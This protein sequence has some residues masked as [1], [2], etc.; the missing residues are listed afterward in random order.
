MKKV[1]SAVQWLLEQS[2]IGYLI[3]FRLKGY[4]GPSGLPEAPWHNAVLKSRAEVTSALE[5]VAKLDLPE[6]GDPPKN[7]DSLAALDC[8]VRS[9]AREAC[10]LD[11]G[12][13]LYSRI[14][15]WLALYGYRKLHGINLVFDRKIK[16]GPITYQY[17]DITH[18]DYAGETFDAITCL[19]VIEHGVN[20]EN[21]L[22][23]MLRI[24]KPGGLLITST[25]Y[26]LTPIDTKGRQ[27][28]GVPVHIFTKEEILEAVDL[29]ERIG[30]V[31]TGTIDFA[32]GEKVI[33]WNEIDLDYTFLL[34]TLRKPS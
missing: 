31:K 4:R 12:T 23:E 26:W 28:F 7:W 2:T 8:I 18:T 20:L 1:K 6:M 10:I 32:S 13:E 3:F 30:F 17:G 14:L 15:P 24:L 9:T 33:H 11:G 22:R 25:D 34:F 29:A 21:Y 5:Q 19:S 27:A 16:R